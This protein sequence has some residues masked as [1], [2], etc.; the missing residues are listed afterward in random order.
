MNDLQESAR[1]AIRKE[2]VEAKRRLKFAHDSLV[3]MGKLADS[4]YDQSQTP[5][6]TGTDVHFRAKECLTSLAAAMSYM[7]SVETRS[8]YLHNHESRNERK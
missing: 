5:V 1:R 4:L 7:R 8:G 2:I 6:V 3:A